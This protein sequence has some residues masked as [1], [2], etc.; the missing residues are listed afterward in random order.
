[1][2]IAIAIFL[3]AVL[4]IPAVVTMT[5]APGLAASKPTEFSSEQKKKRKAAAKKTKQK[6]D[7]SL[8]TA[9]SEP[10]KE[11]KSTY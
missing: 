7:E 2:R 8:K 10:P 6:T 5:G 11:N 1:M 3:G 4:A 9:P